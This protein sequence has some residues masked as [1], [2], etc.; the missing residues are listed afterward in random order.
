MLYLMVKWEKNPDCMIDVSCPF[1]ATLWIWTSKD[2]C[3]SLRLIVI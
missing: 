1:E 2:D 3:V